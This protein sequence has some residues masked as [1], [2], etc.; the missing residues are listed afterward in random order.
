MIRVLVPIETFSHLTLSATYFALEF[1]K[2]NPAKIFFLILDTLDEKI[3]ATERSP[4]TDE[5]WPALFQQLLQQ[6]RE[7]QVNLVIHHSQED[8]LSAIIHMAEQ[9][10]IDDIIIAV[11]SP[12]DQVHTQIQRLIDL[13]RRQVQCHIITVKPKEI[14][15][16]LDSW[17]KKKTIA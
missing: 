6:G 3:Q 8:Y 15:N 11:P 16:M 2:R 17:G 7:Q 10:N 13:L 14:A 12:G 9:H 5:Q 1:A 4:M